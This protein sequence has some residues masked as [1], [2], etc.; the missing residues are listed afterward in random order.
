MKVWG[1]HSIE[2]FTIWQTVVA[3]IVNGYFVVAT[4]STSSWSLYRKE[5]VWWRR[6]VFNDSGCPHTLEQ[7]VPC[8]TRHASSLLMSSQF[9]FYGLWEI[10]LQRHYWP[11]RKPRI[12]KRDKCLDRHWSYCIHCFYRRGTGLP[13]A[14]AYLCRS[15]PLS[16]NNTSWFRDWS[17]FK[18]LHSLPSYG[19]SIYYRFTI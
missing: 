9:G 1:A 5:H 16:N 7:C 2:V 17:W 12:L 8:P 15:Y 14:L 13:P 4:E 10:P 11:S 3:P 19:L 6:I 18:A